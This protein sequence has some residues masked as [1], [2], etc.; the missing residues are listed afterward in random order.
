MP[1]LPGELLNQRYRIVHL[2]AEGS[3][4]AVY[5]AR[6]IVIQQDVAIKE[7]LDSSL[8]IQR[9]FRKEAQKLS[10]LAHPQLPK[11]LDHFAL[12]NSGQFLVSE[13]IDGVDLQSLMAQYGRLPSDLIINWLQSIAE[14]L[15]FLHQNNQLH[16]NIKPANIRL[17]PD[18]TVYLVNTGL[19]GLG[20]R[21]RA[22]G[23]GAPEQQTQDEVSEVTDIYSLGA[24]LYAMLT[25]EI[26]PMALKRES[27]LDEMK[28]AREVNADVEPYLSLVATRAL[29]LKA[30]T[31]YETAVDFSQAL[32]RPYGQQ[33][34]APPL[35]YRRTVSQL[36]QQVQP[37]LPPSRRRQ[38][39]QRTV[40]GLAGIASILILILAVI[41]V[42]SRPNQNE[43]EGTTVAEATATVA[44]A[45]VAAATQLAPTDTPVPFPTETP[46]PTPEP[47]LT[48]SGARMLYIPGG[49]FRMGIDDGDENEAPSHLIRLSAFFIDETEVTNRE[50]ALCVDDGA[51]QPPISS[52]ATYHEAYYGDTSFDEYPVIFVN[53]FQA[54]TFCTWRGGRL[55]SEAEWEMAAGFDA[56]QALIFRYPWGDAFDGVKANYCDSNCPI[57]RRDGEFD[58]GHQDTSPVGSFPD[59]RSPLGLYDMSGNVLEWVNDWYDPGYYEE[60]VDTNPLGPT[61]GEFKAIRGGSWLSSQDNLTVSARNSFD[62]TVARAN[63]GFRCAMDGG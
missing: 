3:Y 7:Y 27:G 42:T 8:D 2:L 14:P 6:D 35:E 57:D 26:P 5:R 37:K 44:S 34:Q 20:V 18:G 1:L 24:T 25:G 28:A 30:D 16:L 40:W 56:E 13:Y 50:Y 11:V 41:F 61:E 47:F 45:I 23:Y 32:N 52:A 51:C 58:D 63:L 31:R 59:G 39:E 36:G 53:W 4:G 10:K 33:P 43:Q 17:S 12:D 54:E 29:S 38:I 55:P 22:T 60:S 48:D 9:R 62:P 15:T 49:I 19:P 21:P 46:R